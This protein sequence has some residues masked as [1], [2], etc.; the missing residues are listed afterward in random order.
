KNDKVGAQI[1][2]LERTIKEQNT[3]KQERE[4]EL[5][6][7]NQLAENL[8]FQLNPQD[9]VLFDEQ[10]VAAEKKKTHIKGML[11]KNHEEIIGSSILLSEKKKTFES[12]SNELSV[13]RS[14][15]NNITGDSARIRNEILM[16]TGA[17]A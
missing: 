4:E 14:Q 10:R 16:A 9:K 5:K 11:E 17:T 6:I 13:L 8:E 2:T 1:N 7:Y 15:K 3:K 12:L